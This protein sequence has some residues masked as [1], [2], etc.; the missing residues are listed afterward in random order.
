MSAACADCRH[1]DP[2]ETMAGV[3]RCRAVPPKASTNNPRIEGGWWAEW[4]LV[5]AHDWCGE[6]RAADDRPVP[7]RVAE[8]SE[9]PSAWSRQTLEGIAAKYA[10]RRLATEGI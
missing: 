10:G 5:Y 2:D 8:P 4:P 9:Y 3:G 6:Y 7:H 1:F